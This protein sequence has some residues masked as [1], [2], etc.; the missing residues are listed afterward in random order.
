VHFVRSSD[1]G[2]AQ[3]RA[4]CELSTLSD[5]GSSCVFGDIKDRLT[6]QCKQWV[7]AASPTK[8]MSQSSAK[9]ANSSILAFLRTYKDSNF[10]VSCTA[11]CVQ[12][13]VDC[14]VFAL[15]AFRQQREADDAAASSSTQ[16]L[17]RKKMGSAPWWTTLAPESNG[18]EPLSFGISGLVCTDWCALGE[19]RRGGGLT[20]PNHHVWEV[21][22]TFTAE[23][24]LEDLFFSE[25]SDRY[26]VVSLKVS[27]RDLGFPMRR[28]RLFTAGLCK[29]KWAWIGPS[30]CEEVQDEFIKFFGSTCELTGDV[31]YAADSAE[32]EQMVQEMSS[33]RRK[34]LPEGW[35]K[36]RMSEY[37]HMISCPSAMVR[38]GEYDNQ[39]HIK[40]S[41]GGS[42][43]ADLDHNPGF[44]PSPGP[45]MPS[46]DTHPTIFSWLC[47]RLATPMELLAAQGVDAYSQLSGGRSLSPLHTLFQK[48][49]SNKV[50]FM[51]GNSMHIPTH[52]AWMLYVISRMARREE[53]SGMGNQ[54]GPPNID[55][56]LDIDD[57]TVAV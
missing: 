4:L 52:A 25:N 45:D 29:R 8:S 27:P 24:D 26:P 16:P 35:K 51:A 2:K 31:Y 39:M 14:P 28:R 37:L 44:G 10:K 13:G 6:A 41:L 48:Y 47:G 15:H 18:G 57:A 22:K 12:H 33:K 34:I 42:F 56:A 40:Q 36:M 20:E 54:V 19:Q 5:E 38:K 49:S 1:W 11:P 23:K 43:L 55:S 7:E 3:A 50:R 30:T 46:L 9:E 21:E 17:K 53:H 32:I